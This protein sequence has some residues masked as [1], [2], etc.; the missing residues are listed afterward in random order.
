MVVHAAFLG[1]REEVV[2]EGEEEGFACSWGSGDQD[3]LNVRLLSYTLDSD[4]RAT[5]SVVPPLL[6]SIRED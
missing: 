3:A 4:L 5:N 6:V 1:C 2:E